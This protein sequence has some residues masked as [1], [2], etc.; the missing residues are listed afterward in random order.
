MGFFSSGLI[1]AGLLA[2]GMS[3]S[4][5][6]ED[7]NARDPR[8]KE[9]QMFVVKLIPAGKCL[10]VLITGK[11]AARVD[12]GQLGMQATLF[13]GD[14]AVSLTPKRD[15]DRFIIDAAQAAHDKASR[16]KIE[17]KEGA[18][19]EQFEFDKLP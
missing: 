16:L 17:V 1:A 15:K 14:K 18:K 19:Q 3:A 12:F 11:E 2:V 6:T 5:Q 13:V 4:A 10:Q 7:L 9:G 8:L